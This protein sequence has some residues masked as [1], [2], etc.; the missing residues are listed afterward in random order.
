MSGPRW[1]FQKPFE[2]ATSLFGPGASGMGSGLFGNPGLET[3]ENALQNLSISVDQTPAS[4]FIFHQFESSS[5]DENRITPDPEAV[6]GMHCHKST[7][8]YYF[9]FLEEI[10]VHD[11][12]I[13]EQLDEVRSRI[14]NLEIAAKSRA[15][16]TTHSRL[17]NFCLLLRKRTFLVGAFLKTK[18]DYS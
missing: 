16:T 6:K 14:K 11:L 18:T 7:W 1:V 15:D 2:N 8:M 5:E 13:M 17:E 9:Q 3:P 4:N 12:C 10:F